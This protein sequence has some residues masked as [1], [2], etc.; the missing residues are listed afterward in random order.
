[1]SET[2]NINERLI[3]RLKDAPWLVGNKEDL[4][5]MIGGAGGIGSW[6]SLALVRAGFDVFIQDFDRIEEHNIGGQLYRVNDIGMFKTASTAKIIKDFTGVDIRYSTERIDTTSPTNPIIISAFDNIEA[7]R[8]MFERWS[9]VYSGSSKAIF[10]DGRLR[11]EQIQIFCIKGTDTEGINNY[12]N[13]YLPSDSSIEDEVCTFKQTSH[14]A[15]MMSGFITSFL[16]N[17]ITNYIDGE[18]LRKVP[19]FFE[20]YTPIAFLNI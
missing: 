8:I 20:Y 2:Q 9:S 5:V 19:F 10:I 3:A 6:T 12:L 11:A 16:T 15:A 1:M 7:R 18:E 17:F 4:S 13:N 14:V